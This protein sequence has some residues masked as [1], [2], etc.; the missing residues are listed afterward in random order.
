MRHPKGWYPIHAAVLT[1]DVA[2][3]DV[4]LSQVGVNVD[5]TDNSEISSPWS[6]EEDLRIRKEEL[7]G[8]RL[9]GQRTKGATPLHYAC[10][11]GN[12]EI[13]RRLVDR[14]ASCGVGD[15]LWRTP[16]DYFSVFTADTEALKEFHMMYSKWK[17][18]WGQFNGT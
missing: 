9:G 4:V 1:G 13:I 12:L 18:H 16:L 2:L 8:G 7:C 15:E 14:G 10:R 17:G 3:V 6:A 11:I 5:V